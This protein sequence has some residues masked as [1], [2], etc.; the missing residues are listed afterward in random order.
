M[1]TISNHYRDLITLLLSPSAWF[2]LQ[3]ACNP[4]PPP[5]QCPVILQHPEPAALF[6]KGTVRSLTHLCLLKQS[7]GNHPS[8]SSLISL[9]CSR[10]QSCSN[11]WAAIRPYPNSHLPQM[12]R[13]AQC[14]LFAC[15]FNLY[16][17]LPVIS[18]CTCHSLDTLLPC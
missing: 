7:C 6:G 10:F 12:F 5:L 16:I 13:T 4:L 17:C 8:K 2:N 15:I 3:P 9:W 1:Y 11:I 14:P 18:V